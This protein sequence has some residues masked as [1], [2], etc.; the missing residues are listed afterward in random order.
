[1]AIRRRLGHHVGADNAVGP[2][3]I[4]NKECLPHLLGELGRDNAR[5]DVGTAGT[6]GHDDFHRFGRIALRTDSG[7]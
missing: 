7:R 5:H 2:A 3:V 1:M 4:L 6:G